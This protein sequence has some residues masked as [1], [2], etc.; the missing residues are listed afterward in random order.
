MGLT[1]VYLLAYNLAQCVLWTK[2]LA[3]ITTHLLNGGAVE[4]CYA[5]FRF[6]MLL[7]IF[8]GLLEVLH[9]ILKITRSNVMTC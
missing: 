1:N 4:S 7:A 6:D 2:V 5:E 8:A 3:T 9:A